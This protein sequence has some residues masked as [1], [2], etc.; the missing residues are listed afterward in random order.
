M[1]KIIIKLLMKLLLQENNVNWMNLL[2]LAI[3]SSPVEEKILKINL[4]DKKFLNLF[5]N[6]PKNNEFIYSS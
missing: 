1:K 6:Y 2:K 3:K 4:Q 5:Q